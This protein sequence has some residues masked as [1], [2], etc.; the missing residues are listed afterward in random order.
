MVGEK[1][2]SRGGAEKEQRGAE[3]GGKGEREKERKRSAGTGGWM[4]WHTETP[5]V[6]FLHFFS[7]HVSCLSNMMLDGLKIRRKEE[8]R[9]AAWLIQVPPNFGQRTCQSQ[10]TLIRIG[11]HGE[12]VKREGVYYVHRLFGTHTDCCFAWRLLLTMMTW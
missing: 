7:L 12:K 9:H 11:L 6:S 8:N 5:L 3:A 2:R 1:R 10:Q 4:T